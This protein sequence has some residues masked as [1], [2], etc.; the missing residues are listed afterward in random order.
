MGGPLP[1][2]VADSALQRFTAT[3]H[4]ELSLDEQLC[5]PLFVRMKH[6]MERS[7]HTLLPVDRVRSARERASAFGSP[8]VTI[9][10][11]IIVLIIILSRL[12][13][14]FSLKDLLRVVCML[15]VAG[16]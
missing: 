10:L 13:L 7:I 16:I 1:D 12:N 3:C 14:N 15:N 8:R 6:E 9:S 11:E 4:I 5:E 2:S